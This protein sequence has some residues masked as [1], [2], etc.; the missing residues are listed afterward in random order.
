MGSQQCHSLWHSLLLRTL[1]SA[2][3]C[4][5]FLQV[6]VWGNYGRMDRK[7]FMGMARILLEELDLSTM[8]IGWYKLFPTSSMVDPKMAPL[9]RHSSQMSLEST[10]GPCCER[11][12]ASCCASCQVSQVEPEVAVLEQ[13]CSPTFPFIHSQTSL[14]FFFLHFWY[15]LRL[16]SQSLTGGALLL[17]L[18]LNNTS[19]IH[20]WDEEGRKKKINKKIP[21]SDLIFNGE[22]KRKKKKKRI[23]TS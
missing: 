15:R 5:L 6:I 20:W 1:E 10:I 14:V 3:L 21:S 13:T 23:K 22:K 12:W 17:L 8:V 7:C 9:I 19:L 4:P 11:P 18:P 16:V 2:H